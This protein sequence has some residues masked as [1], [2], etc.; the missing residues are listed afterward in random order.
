MERAELIS[1]I[2][3]C[4][5]GIRRVLINSFRWSEQ[6][7]GDKKYMATC[8]CLMS[9]LLNHKCESNCEWVFEDGA[10]TLTTNR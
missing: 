1:L 7:E 5:L 10:I 8:L 4:L 6:G 9:S 2:E 3:S